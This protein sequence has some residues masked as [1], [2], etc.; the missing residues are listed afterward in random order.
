M[1]QVIV[2]TGGIGCGK[3]T[4]MSSLKEK[5]PDADFFSFDKFTEELYHEASVRMFLINNFQTVDRKVISKLVFANPAL[6]QVLDDYFFP[7]AEAKLLDL[8]RQYH[9]SEKSIYIECPMFS[10]MFYRSPE[11][12]NNRAKL[13]VIVVTCDKDE[14]ISRVMMRDKL[15]YNAAVQRVNSRGPQV[16]GDKTI[17]TSK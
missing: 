5:F 1:R 14:Q 4:V 15:S 17:D 3:S 13:H 16:V 8:I 6:K 2:I 10:E 9:R 11:L 7:I 12:I